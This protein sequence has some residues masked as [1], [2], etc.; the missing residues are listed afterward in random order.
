VL[1]ALAALLWLLPPGPA[2]AGDLRFLQLFTPAEQLG[3]ELTLQDLQ[4]PPLAPLALA[5]QGRQRRSR[6]PFVALPPTWRRPWRQLQ[7]TTP[8]WRWQRAQLLTASWPDLPAPVVVPLVLHS[9]GTVDVFL[10]GP[11]APAVTA[12]LQSLLTRLAMPPKGSVQPLQLELQPRPLLSL[13]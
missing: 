11:G 8:A 5:E 4:A 2:Q 6:D 1:P 13:Q 12:A 9:D 3:G 10:D 7:A